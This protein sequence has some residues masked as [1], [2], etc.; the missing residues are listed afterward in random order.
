MSGWFEVFATVLI[1]CLSRV[2]RLLHRPLSV[3]GDLLVMAMVLVSVA[4][5]EFALPVVSAIAAL[6]A[7]SAVLFRRG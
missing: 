3:R 2:P 4:A 7:V 1:V 5:S 6:T